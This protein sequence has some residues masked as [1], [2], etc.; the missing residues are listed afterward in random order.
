MASV[1][2]LWTRAPAWLCGRPSLL[3]RQ[4]SSGS[5]ACGQE[6]QACHGIARINVVRLSGCSAM[7]TGLFS[8]SSRREERPA[9]HQTR[10]GRPE[11]ADP[12]WRAD[13]SGRVCHEPAFE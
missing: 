9:F 10:N 11:L 2:V 8:D 5:G 7:G 12:K 6:S 4:L 3:G 1:E 13:F